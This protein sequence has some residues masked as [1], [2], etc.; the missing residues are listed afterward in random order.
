MVGGDASTVG[1]AVEKV[2]IAVVETG[3]ETT[4]DPTRNLESHRLGWDELLDQ[5]VAAMEAL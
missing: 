5:L 4:A 1:A 2:W 3:F